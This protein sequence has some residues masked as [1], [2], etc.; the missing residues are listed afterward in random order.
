M[1]SM[2]YRYRTFLGGCWKKSVSKKETSFEEPVNLRREPH[3]YNK[4]SNS[5]MSDYLAIY[6]TFNSISATRYC[7]VPQ[8]PWSCWYISPI[9]N[10]ASPHYHEDA[11]APSIPTF[12]LTEKKCEVPHLVLPSACGEVHLK[13]CSK[14]S[15]DFFLPSDRQSRYLT[16]ENEKLWLCSDFEIPKVLWWRF[17]VFLRV[18]ELFVSQLHSRTFM[19]SQQKV[20]APALVPCKIDNW[21]EIL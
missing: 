21:L 8:I 20:T 13:L 18:S 12:P 19:I 10:G 6:P 5:T 17:I 9:K 2:R 7:Q 16:S 4:S 14:V 1:G 11:G 15:K 3:L